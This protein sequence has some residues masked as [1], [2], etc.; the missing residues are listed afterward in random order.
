MELSSGIEASSSVGFALDE[1]GCRA[2]DQGCMRYALPAFGA[3]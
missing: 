1:S 2:S 3:G